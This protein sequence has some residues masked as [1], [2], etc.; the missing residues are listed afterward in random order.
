MTTLMVIDPEAKLS[1]T[2]YDLHFTVKC[3][4]VGSQLKIN[5]KRLKQKL[6]CSYG[7]Q[8]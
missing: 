8:V 6:T 4:L 1:L 5:Q 3:V 2:H 7:K